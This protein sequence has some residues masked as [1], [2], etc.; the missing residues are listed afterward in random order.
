MIPFALEVFLLRCYMIVFKM[1]TVIMPFKWPQVVSGAGSSL[2]L[3]AQIAADGH[4]R[5]LIVTDAMLV[6]LGLLDAMQAELAKQGVEYVIFDGVQPDPTIEQ[7][8]TGVKALEDNNCRAVLA[9]GGGSS[10][11]AAK[12]I[13]ARGTNKKPIAKMTGLFRVYRRILPLYAVPTTA[14]T[15]SEVTVAAVVSD[16][17]QQ[18][19]LP[20]MDLKLMPDRAA[21]DGD[22]MKG[23]PPAITAAT[24]MDALTHAVEAYISRNA[25]KRTDAKAIE[26]TQLILANL[27]TAVKDGGNIEARQNMVW[28]S[29]QAGIAFTQAGVGYVH[30]ISHNFGARYHTPHGLANAIVLPYVLEYSKEKCA[31]RLAGL[32]RAC[33]L[34]QGS[35]V[36]LADR[37]IARIRE[38]NAEFNIPESLDALQPADIPAIAQAALAEARFTYA[39]PRYMNRQSCEALIRQILPA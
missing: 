37:F 19:K 23:L 36:Q 4:K 34:G 1:V 12:V 38:M 30:A 28:A 2:E 9:V 10:I 5:V 35:D 22:L 26:A 8:E 18:R 29:H 7:I 6:K 15:G 16:P 21:L 20:I 11:D 17:D 33:G 24:G 14:G 25:L 32:A 27:P 3:C 31:D 39:V 13:A